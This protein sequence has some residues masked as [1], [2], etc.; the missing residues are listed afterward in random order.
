MK[1]YSYDTNKY[2]FSEE[3]KK[4]YGVRDL[5]LIHKQW[6][7]AK[8]YD[9]LDDVK[10]DQDTDYH[11]TF[12]EMATPEFYRIYE[13]FLNNVIFPLFDEPILYQKIPTFRVHQ[14][15]NIAVAAFHMDK[16]Y[17]HASDEVN[18]FLPLTEA[19]GNTTIWAE[20]EI[21]KAD[22]KPMEGEYGEFWLWDGANL[23]HGNKVND[24]DLCRVSIDFRL[25]P[26]SKYTDT[27]QV[28]TSNDV[29]MSVGNYW[30]D[31]N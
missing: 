31:A 15:Q 30:K 19:K 26:K 16:E 5:D 22:Y 4:L 12:Y 7:G 18:I 17:S 24:S 3:V 29:Q 11:Q 14:P 10:T 2:P 27:E 1:K 23:T 9:L 20:S 13:A 21:G 25:L 8:K 6:I 28:S